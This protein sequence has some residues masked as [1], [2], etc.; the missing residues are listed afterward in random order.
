[1]MW[2]RKNKNFIQLLENFYVD[3]AD[4]AIL[5]S[6]EVLNNAKFLNFEK[7]WF[8]YFWFSWVFFVWDTQMLWTSHHLPWINFK[9]SLWITSYLKNTRHSEALVH[10]DDLDEK[11]F[12][13]TDTIWECLRTVI[14]QTFM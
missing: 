10:A 4:H 8:R 5:F 6:D 9:K 7:K 12:Y 1:M 11:Q 13:R 14:V 3:A 2:H